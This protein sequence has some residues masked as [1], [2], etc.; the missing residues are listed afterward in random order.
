MSQSIV[1]YDEILKYWFG[2]VEETIVPTEHRAKIW[3]GEDDA[4]DQEIKTKF[5]GHL[6]AAL[7]GELDDWAD[8][9]RGQLALIIVS[10][11]F[12]RHVYR[13]SE[14]A[15]LLD[16]KALTTCL[17]GMHVE[18]DHG[19]SLIER[20]FYYFPLLHSERMSHQEQSI[21]AHSR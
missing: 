9:S 21:R 10:D 11:Q 19:L 6:D 15:F 2:H 4:V 17:E 7:R 5:S 3:F 20:V 8:S 14:N 1:S 13:H 16:M 12:A 18:A